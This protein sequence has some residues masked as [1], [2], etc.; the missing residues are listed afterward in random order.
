MIWWE[1]GKRGEKERE[2]GVGGGRE[3]EKGRGGGGGGCEKLRMS[4]HYKV[5]IN[6]LK[7]DN[8]YVPSVLDVFFFHRVTWPCHHFE[9]LTY[10]FVYLCMHY[11]AFCEPS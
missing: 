10:L 11:V 3:R 7:S 9:L 2:R 1:S 5:S 6:M 4:E 8:L